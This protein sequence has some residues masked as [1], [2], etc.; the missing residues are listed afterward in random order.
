[1]AI[2]QDLFKGVPDG[3]IFP[4]V[5]VD[6]V[7]VQL[8]EPANLRAGAQAA[9]LGVEEEAHH[10]R[11]LLLEDAFVLRIDQSS[12]GIEAVEGFHRIMLTGEELE[13][14]NALGVIAG[15][16][17]LKG[18]HQGGA[19]LV[20]VAGVAV[21][22]PHEGLAAPQNILSGEVE[23]GGHHAL[24]AQG[25]NVAGSAL[26]AIVQLVADAEEKVK[27]FLDFGVGNAGES[28]L[29]EQVAQVARLSQHPEDPNEVVVVSQAAAAF[30]DVGLL[31]V[32]CVAVALVA[33]PDVAASFR[34]VALL[35]APNAMGEEGLLEAGEK[36]GVARDETGVEEGGL[37]LVIFVGKGTG[38]LDGAHRIAHLQPQ[39]E[40]GG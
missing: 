37:G 28:S 26:L 30:L 8:E 7:P 10:P 21:V 13:D 15:D 31:Q 36:L 6:A 27:G 20:K 17:E 11:R 14:G 39:V 18:L 38:F 25:E 29:L 5:P 40:E 4:E 19:V 24:E 16:L 12:L 3:P 9:A 35:M 34:Q 22:I 32:G 2:L 1:A 33:R 23:L